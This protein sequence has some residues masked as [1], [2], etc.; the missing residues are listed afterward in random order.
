MN[1]FFICF[2]RRSLKKERNEILFISF[3]FPPNEVLK[4]DKKEAK[5]NIDIFQH[6]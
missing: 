1:L 5:L 2:V 6:I 4:Q 3:S